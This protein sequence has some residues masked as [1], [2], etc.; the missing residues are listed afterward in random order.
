MSRNSDKNTFFIVSG[1]HG[2]IDFIT[3]TLS[4]NFANTSVFHACDWFDIKYKLENVRPKIIFVDEYLPRSSG[5]E[6]V[7]KIMK[8]KTNAGVHIVIMSYVADQGMYPNESKTGRIQYLTEPDRAEAIIDVVAKIISPK[9]AQS[10]NKQADFRLVHL[11]KGDVLFKEGENTQVVYIVKNGT[12]R[13]Y[14][15]STEGS[16]VNLGDIASGEF[17]GE[18]GHF[19]REPRSATVEA[20]TDVELIEIPMSSLE[21]VIFSKPSWAK[22]LVKTLAQRLKKANKALAS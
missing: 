8:E 11:T 19:N 4:K 1:D 12:L 10:E 17:V 13:A 5:M 18:M 3:D 2:R 20:V 16:R 7:A 21:N 15:D 9:T 22:A 14:T 6:I